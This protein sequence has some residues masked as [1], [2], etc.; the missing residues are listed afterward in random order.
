M[1]FLECGWGATGFD[2]VDVTAP[3]WRRIGSRLKGIIGN[4]VQ[5][6]EVAGRRKRTLKMAGKG[7]ER[8]LGWLAFPTYGDRP[9][10]L[11]NN[12]V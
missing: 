8:T 6:T 9:A 11:S 4:G 7:G 5:G 1:F 2:A 12:A 10:P 3:T